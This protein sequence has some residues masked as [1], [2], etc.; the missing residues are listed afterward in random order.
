MC[1]LLCVFV[2]VCRSF[3]V[4][5]DVL[6]V[7]SICAISRLNDHVDYISSKIRGLSDNFDADFRY[8][9]SNTNMALLIL[10]CI[11]SVH[12]WPSLH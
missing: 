9:I 11:L 1:V 2:F 10:T 3:W 7:G 8:C 5:C 12:Q 4:H 6:Y